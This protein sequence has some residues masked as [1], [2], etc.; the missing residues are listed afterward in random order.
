MIYEHPL[1][2]VL[3]QSG[4]LLKEDLSW[5]G[6]QFVQSKGMLTSELCNEP[7]LPVTWKLLDFLCWWGFSPLHSQFTKH[8]GEIG[9]SDAPYTAYLYSQ[10]NSG[11]GTLYYLNRPARSVPCGRQWQMWDAALR[12]SHTGSLLSLIYPARAN[13]STQ[14]QAVWKSLLNNSIVSQWWKKAV[15][16]CELSVISGWNKIWVLFIC[17]LQGI[18]LELTIWNLLEFYCEFN[19]N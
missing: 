7:L 14:A 1:W 8:I 13:L 3:I 10:H 12:P 17:C 19:T 5:V 15:A 11:I 4:F 6:T 9:H 16:L 2:L 18:R